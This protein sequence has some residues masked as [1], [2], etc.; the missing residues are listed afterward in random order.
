M[1]RATH[2]VPGLLLTEHEFQVPLD[3]HLF[4]DAQLAVVERLEAA[5]VDRWGGP[6]LDRVLAT[7]FG[8]QA[9]KESSTSS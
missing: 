4:L 6:I 9:V 7:R 5:L 8:A 2:R 1:R 3:L